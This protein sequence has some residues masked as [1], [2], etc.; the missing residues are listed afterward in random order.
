MKEV[1]F[2]LALLLFFLVL[3]LLR[4]NETGLKEEIFWFNKKF[5][6]LWS[7][8]S[9]KGIENYRKMMMPDYLFSS[10]ISRVQMVLLWIWMFMWINVPGKNRIILVISFTLTLGIHFLNAQ[11]PRNSYKSWNDP[12]QPHLFKMCF[13]KFILTIVSWKINV[14]LP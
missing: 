13:R 12:S 9:F 1:Q 7:L 6:Q 14:H 8:Q 3:R 4:A 10:I 5:S 11:T 2:H